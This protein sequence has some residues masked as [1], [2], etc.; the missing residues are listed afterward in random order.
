MLFH[1]QK[2]GLHDVLF[3]T[4][5]VANDF[6]ESTE[7]KSFCVKPV[8]GG[9]IGL[10]ILA[11]SFGSLF[12]NVGNNPD[13][14]DINVLNDKIKMESRNKN[15]NATY[16]TFSKDGK[17]TSFAIEVYVPIPYDKFDDKKFTDE[18]SSKLYPL[19]KRVN[20]NPK[21]D[22]ITMLFQAQKFIGAFPISKT[23]SSPKKLSEIN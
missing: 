7:I 1:P 11:I 10:A 22:T 20:S 16:R 8:I 18:L 17:Q 9:V 15:I 13:F 12:Y 23:S 6:E 3:K 5:V 2:R 14:S 21:V 4:V 19:V